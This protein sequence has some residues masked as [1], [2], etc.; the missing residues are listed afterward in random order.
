M[1]RLVADGH[2]NRK[3]AETLF[4]STKTV[5][6]HVSNIL[7][8][9]HLGDRAEAIVQARQAGLTDSDTPHS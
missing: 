8:K 2:N 9:L 1:L 4:L 7:N 5:A 3:I 6:N